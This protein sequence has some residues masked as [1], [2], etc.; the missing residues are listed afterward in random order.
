MTDIKK[1]NHLMIM[2]IISAML[3]FG[4]RDFIS[5]SANASYI[6]CI[7][8]S[9]VAALL[10]TSLYN[11]QAV[12]SLLN[13]NGIVGKIVCIMLVLVFLM[14]SA[15][16]TAKLVELINKF[17]MQKSPVPYLAFF[18]IFPA[19]F[20]GYFGIKST[21]RYAS[22]VWIITLIATAFILVM[23]GGEYNTD[24]LYPML[25]NGAADLL[26][27]S[28]NISVFAVILIYFV[29]IS[30][31]EATTKHIKKQ[32]AKFI[33]ISGVFGAAVCLA[34]SLLLPYRAVGFADNPYLTVAS[35]IRANF[36]L[37]RSEIVVLILWIFCSFLCVSAFCAGIFSA[38]GKMAKVSDKRGI[39][40]AVMAIIYLVT[41]LA[42]RLGF[43]DY[44][45]DASSYALMLLSVV[46]PVVAYIRY[47]VSRRI[48]K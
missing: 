26:K 36:M 35:S 11:H 2:L 20:G 5:N 29:M 44:I 15:A 18:C 6:A 46:I 27:G 21:S 10:Y 25:G 17:F 33:L 4:L 43:A 39:I 7:L 22:I 28:L 19:S 12:K 31:A 16:F 48:D 14:Y 9:A 45:V 23:C 42:H 38:C 34:L 47:F 13:S 37:E 8:S 32:I 24:N 30:D 40:G 3:V 41:I 1:Y